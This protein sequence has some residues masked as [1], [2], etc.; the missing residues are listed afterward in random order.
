MSEPK[1]V[2]ITGGVRRLGLS[3]AKAFA[4]KGARLALNYHSSPEEEAETARREV[5]QAGASEVTLIKGDVTTEAAR[6]VAESHRY[7]IP[8]Q[9]GRRGGKND[10]ATLGL[11]EG[12]V[13]RPD[14]KRNAHGKATHYVQG[15]IHVGVV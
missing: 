11:R 4:A 3:M 10:E 15:R 5:L 12:E 14:T 1:R 8:A 6:I 7:L 2:L 9:E 13:G